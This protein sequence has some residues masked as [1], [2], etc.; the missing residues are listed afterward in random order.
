MDFW[1][2]IVLIV[3]IG[4]VGDTIASRRKKR[5]T[6]RAVDKRLKNLEDSVPDGDVAAHLR[7][8]DERLRNVE[9]IVTDSRHE[10]DREIGALKT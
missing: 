4:V 10:L 6:S 8:I 3:L 2:A 1:T 9:K 7:K 5:V